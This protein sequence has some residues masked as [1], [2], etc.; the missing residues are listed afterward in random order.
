MREVELKEAFKKVVLSREFTIIKEI[1]NSSPDMIISKDGLKIGVE[2]KSQN[3]I[4]FAEAIGQLLFG[5][6]KFK[7]DKL[8]LVIPVTPSKSALGWLKTLWKH[9][10]QVFALINGN[11]IR[12][13]SNNLRH[14]VRERTLILCSKIFECIQNHPEGLTFKEIAKE[15]GV[16]TNTVKFNINGLLKKDKFW[17]A[18]LKDMI[19]IE[20]DKVKPIKHKS[21]SDEVI[22]IFKNAYKI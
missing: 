17:G 8:W 21:V 10:V 5:K 14:F 20:G 4:Q 2:F 1:T 13:K 7:L 11:L 6:F 18:N 9:H 15:I 3:P 19:V 16:E 12:I 22:Q